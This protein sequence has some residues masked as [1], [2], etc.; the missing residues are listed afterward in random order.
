LLPGSL[1]LGRSDNVG[2]ELKVGIADFFASMRD[3]CLGHGPIEI[4]LGHQLGEAVP[5]LGP[6]FFRSHRSLSTPERIG[7]CSHGRRNVIMT[8]H[9]GAMV[10]QSQKSPFL[11]KFRPPEFDAL[12]VKVHQAETAD[13]LAKA[14]FEL[15]ALVTPVLF[16][17]LLFRPLEFELPC[18]FTPPHFKASIDAY[19]QTEHKHDIWL[20]RSP[21]HPGVTVVRHGDYTSPAVFHRSRFYRRLMGKVGIEYAASIVAWRGNTWLATLTVMHSAQQGD[22]ETAIR[23]M[24]SHQ[25]TRLAHSSLKRVVADLPTASVLID[26]DLRPLHFSAVAAQL[27]AKW[28]HGTRSSVLKPSRG[29]QMPGDILA[30]VKSLKSTLITIPGKK[31]EN[32]PSLFRRVI[33]HS[34]QETLSASVEYVPAPALALS[35][36]MFLVT[37]HEDRLA[38]AGETVL[39]KMNRLTSRERECAQ[40][41]GEGLNNREIARALGKSTIT[42]RNQLTSVYRK[43]DLKSRHNLIAALSQL[44]A[45]ERAKMKTGR[46]AKT[47]TAKASP[48]SR[49]RLG[50]SV[51]R[52]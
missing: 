13:Q 4:A 42:V 40:L 17:N 5:K 37:L 7:L 32:D 16:A 43:L 51:P 44:D 28:R 20:K 52:R 23:R 10:H 21:V 29:F 39:P 6:A 49:A 35:K 12:L 1:K 18:K 47:S 50:R 22:F 30:E 48:P 36:G 27:G 2:H 15:V 9:V 14:L 25:E 8:R 46:L 26:W 38:R 45:N 11:A 41:A 31:R 33:T 19:M 24:A 34:R 3:Q